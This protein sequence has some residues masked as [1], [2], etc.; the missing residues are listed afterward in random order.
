FKALILD[1]RFVSFD[2]S[3]RRGEE[4]RQLYLELIDYLAGVIRAAAG[5]GCIRSDDPQTTALMLIEMLTALTRRRLLSLSD[6]TPESDAEIVLDLF[7]Y[8][9][10][11]MHP[12][13]A[14]GR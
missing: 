6:S 5:Q 2:A 12:A 13:E 4:L 10:R 9:V 1:A 3:D 7:M 8:G 14:N 11:G